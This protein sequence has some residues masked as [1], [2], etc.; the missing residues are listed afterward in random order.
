MAKYDALSMEIIP[1]INKSYT[2]LKQVL[3]SLVNHLNFGGWF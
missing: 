3:T 1:S 2:S